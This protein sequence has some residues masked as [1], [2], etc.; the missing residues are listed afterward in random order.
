MLFFDL[1]TNVW[2]FSI[3]V[4]LFLLLFEILVTKLFVWFRGEE[5]DSFAWIVAFIFIVLL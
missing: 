4:R 1:F 5:D 2:R 3:G